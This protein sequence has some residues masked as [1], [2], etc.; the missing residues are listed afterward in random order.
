MFQK[1]D[2]TGL[3][4]RQNVEAREK[5][6]PGS[7]PTGTKGWVDGVLPKIGNV[8]KVESLIRKISWLGFVH[9]EVEVIM[10]HTG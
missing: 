10:E 7:F 5:R 2:L 4:D 1:I 3:N 8:G 6:S 9:I